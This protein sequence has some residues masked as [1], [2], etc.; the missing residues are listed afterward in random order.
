MKL[1]VL[2]LVLIVSGIANAQMDSEKKSDWRFGVGLGYSP[3]LQVKLEGTDTETSTG[4]TYHNNV[5]L[6]Y[7]GSASFSLTA[8]RTPQ[9]SWGFVSGYEYTGQR[10][11]KMATINGI[12]STTALAGSKYQAQN[13]YVGTAYRWEVFFIPLALNYSFVFFQPP[14]LSFGTVEVKNGIGAHLGVGWFIGENFVIEI[15]GRSALT[16]LN[17]SSSSG[18]SKNEGTIASSSLLLSFQY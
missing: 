18:T 10:D 1:K 2:I 16:E 17:M 11:F 9:N 3:Q 14:P 8:W 4:N 5:E 15:L 7:K 6:D 13:L 12:S